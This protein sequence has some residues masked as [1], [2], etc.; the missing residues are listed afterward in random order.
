[1]RLVGSSRCRVYSR[2]FVEKEHC[3]EPFGEPASIVSVPRA[4]PVSRIN[5]PSQMDK[6]FNLENGTVTNLTYDD[7]RQLLS[8][9]HRTAAGSLVRL[10]YAYEKLGNRARRRGRTGVWTSTYTHSATV[11]SSSIFNGLYPRPDH[12]R[13]GDRSRTTPCLLRPQQ[14]WLYNGCQSSRT[15]TC[16]LF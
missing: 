4:V 9:D 5:V 1:M 14:R 8:V 15:R 12:S 10:G 11:E 13:C 16:L 7:G 6:T 3:H 2:R